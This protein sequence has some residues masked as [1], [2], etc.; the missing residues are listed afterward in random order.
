MKSVRFAQ[1][2]EKSSMQTSSIGNYQSNEDEKNSMWYSKIE[3]FEFRNDVKDIRRKRLRQST[4]CQISDVDKSDEYFSS[5]FF[6]SNEQAQDR[7]RRKY[8]AHKIIVEAQHHLGD[9]ELATASCALTEW[10]RVD[11]LNR[12]HDAKMA[13]WHKSHK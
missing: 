6:L 11:A 12:A 7:K 1:Q 5:S 3:I 9:N 13:I 4:D 8:Y 10:A 2:E